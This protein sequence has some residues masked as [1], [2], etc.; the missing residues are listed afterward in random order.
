M[1]YN[2]YIFCYKECVIVKL[3]KILLETVNCSKMTLKCQGCI[4]TWVIGVI[5]LPVQCAVWSTHQ[6]KCCQYYQ[7]V[8]IEIA[9]PSTLSSIAIYHESKALYN[10]TIFC[11][12]RVYWCKLIFVLCYLF[13]NRHFQKNIKKNNT[14]NKA[15][16]IRT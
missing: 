3:I 8:T 13:H 2:T 7:T 1:V 9:I 16:N 4:G 10:F 12:V 6:N 5:A 11:I 14:F 15:Y